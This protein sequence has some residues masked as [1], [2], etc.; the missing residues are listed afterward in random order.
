LRAPTGLPRARAKAIAQVRRTQPAAY[1]EICALLVPKEMKLEHPNP[2]SGLSDEELKQAI[3]ALRAM[4]AQP[5][6]TAKVIEGG[7]VVVPSLPPPKPA[8]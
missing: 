1:L 6:E 2:L 4:L 3:A 8:S 5:G 7:A